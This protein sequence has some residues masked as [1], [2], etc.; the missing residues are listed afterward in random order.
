[1][2]IS[3]NLRFTE[4][5]NNKELDE[6]RMLIDGQEFCAG[7]LYVPKIERYFD[8]VEKKEEKKR[9]RITKPTKN[10]KEIFPYA[11]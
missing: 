6:N 2:V 4:F 9:N 10:D 5:R 11:I 7:K 3:E 8:S 1:M